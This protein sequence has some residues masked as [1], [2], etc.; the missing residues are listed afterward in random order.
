VFITDIFTDKFDVHDV[1]ADGNCLF[2][3]LAFG[4]GTPHTA[5]SVRRD[6]VQ[7]VRDHL[8]E[9]SVDHIP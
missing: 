3:A 1:A 8:E 7:Y 5:E 2:A 4:L 9:V 6:A